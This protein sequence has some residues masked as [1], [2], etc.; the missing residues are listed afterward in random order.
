MSE[1]NGQKLNDIIKFLSSY[2]HGKDTALRLSLVAFFSK[3]HLLIEDLPGLGK[4]TLAIAISKALGLSFGR[5]QCTSDLLPTDITG[6]SI[7]KKD[8]GE[9]EF[10][11]G[12][13]FNNIVLVDE[14][15]RATP[16]TQSA[17]L[18]AMGEKQTTIEGK[19]YRLSKPFFVIAT[20]NPVEQFGTFPL[21]ESQMDRF[22]MKI[23]I[24]YVSREAEK[25]IISGGSRREE[26]YSIEPMM[27]S[28]EVLQIQRD[29]K[30]KV[31]SSSK[32][33]DYIMDIVG[34]TRSSK[35]ILAGLS[36]RGALALNSTAKTNAYFNGRDFVIPEDIKELAEHTIP[37]RVIF[38]E[39]Y[40]S[41]DKKEIVRSII[42]Q[43]AAPA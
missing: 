32:I 24:G 35:F 18:E 29:V 42:D 11:P 12:P 21:P 38:R 19:T 16:K 13:I 39:E 31:Y 34:A 37:H 3:G 25:E 2:L 15:N 43:I 33:M 5:I 7:Y 28:A 10:H 14:I 9:F 30:E 4:T 41:V 20:Q 22:M 8:S 6:L 36:T 23:S 1:T 40:D 17:L 27:S 26:L